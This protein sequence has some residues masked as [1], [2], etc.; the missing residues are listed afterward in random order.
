V[1][2]ESAAERAAKEAF[3]RVCSCIEKNKNFLLEAGAG[4][5]KTHSLISA[6]KYVLARRG[7]ELVRRRQQ[8]A[9]ITFTNVAKGEIEARTGRH[10]AVYSDTVHGFCWSL[11]K[12]FQPQLRKTLAGLT[13]WQAA[14][15]E[16]GGLGA[17]RV[18][19]DLGYMSIND[20]S[21]SLRHDDV[22]S[23]MGRFLELPKFRD[24]LSAQYPILF[25]DEYQDTDAVLVEAIK[26]HFLDAAQGPLIGFFG[27]HWQKIYESTCGKIQHAS[28]EVIGK[29]ANFRSGAAIVQCLNQMRPELPQMV[30]DADLLGEALVFHTN[31][32]SGERQAGAHWK[33]DLPPA[34][35]HNFIKVARNH[36]EKSGWDFDPKKTKILMLTH[37]VLAK[38]QGYPSLPGIFA[39]ND[40]FIKKED[41]HIDFFV[42]ILEPACAAYERKRYGEMFAALGARVPAISSH[43]DKVEWSRFMDA[44]LSVRGEDS[45]GAVTDLIRKGRR[46]RLPDKVEQKEQALERLGPV[47]ADDEL[48]HISRLRKLRSVP[49]KEIIALSQYIEGHTPFAT[50]HGVKGAE[51]ENVLVVVGRGWSKYNFEQ[52]LCLARSEVAS[53]K[54]EFFERNRNLFYVACSRPKMRLA[55]LFTQH[56]S[57]LAIETLSSWFGQGAIISLP[58]NLGL[59]SLAH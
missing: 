38:E 15:G 22:L 30:K 35:A 42:D 26:A 8:I 2:N 31:Q 52:M 53:D 32:W 41:P 9:C 40:A 12:G 45:V 23:L 37:N 16:S 28:L 1:P 34:V 47:A 50:K 5:G 18:E 13:N 57:D 24:L 10:D 7:D 39:N 20:K 44:L 48:S 59:S 55:L 4:A 56:L 49:Y 19:Y 36:L 33:G 54:Q 43:A 3:D 14:L 21:V 58:G 29:R 51:F 27:D 46:L 11:L 6:V 17:R 25:I